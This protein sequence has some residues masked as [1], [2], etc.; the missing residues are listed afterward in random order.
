MP[1]DELIPE[2]ELPPLLDEFVSSVPPQAAS[3]VPKSPIAMSLRIVL[4]IPL[5]ILYGKFN[6]KRRRGSDPV[7]ISA[8]ESPASVMQFARR[9]DENR[10]SVNP[11]V[12]AS[13]SGIDSANCI[14]GVAVLMVA[15]PAC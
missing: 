2:E 1:E 4:P 5:K 9:A 11:A 7:Q 10:K 14:R 12:P 15:Q 3:S 6:I 8:V 13:K